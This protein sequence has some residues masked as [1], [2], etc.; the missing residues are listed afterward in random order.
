MVTRVMLRS[1]CAFASTSKFNVVSVVVT[2]THR[3]CVRRSFSAFALIW[4]HHL[5]N[6]KL[7]QHAL[8]VDDVNAD[9]DALCEQGSSH[10]HYSM[11]IQYS[12]TTTMSGNIHS[13][14]A[15]YTTWRILYNMYDTVTV[16]VVVICRLYICVRLPRVPLRWCKLIKSMWIGRLIVQG[17][18]GG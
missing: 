1:Q 18:I 14:W 11:C 10:H 7:C 9:V 6:V 17:V 4:G 5:H 3:D 8:N 12:T 16:V 13:V 15:C 2:F